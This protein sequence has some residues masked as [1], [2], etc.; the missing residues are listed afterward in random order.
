MHGSR[1]PSCQPHARCGAGVS[2]IRPPYGFV[3]LVLRDGPSRPT[4]PAWPAPFSTLDPS[5]ATGVAGSRFIP[6]L[7]A[8]L[9]FPPAYRRP[10]CMDLVFGPFF[11]RWAG[12]PQFLR[13]FHVTGGVREEP[14]SP[15]GRRSVPQIPCGHRQH[16]CRRNSPTDRRRRPALAKRQAGRYRTQPVR[17]RAGAPARLW[18]AVPDNIALPQPGRRLHQDVG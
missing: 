8:G 17:R 3:T 5:V 15:K 6:D 14:R 7:T 13:T 11:L 4:A 10:G 16:P 12:P 18:V 9:G 2:P 1:R